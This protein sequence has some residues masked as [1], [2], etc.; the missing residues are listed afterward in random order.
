VEII[1]FKKQKIFMEII[2]VLKFCWTLSFFIW[3]I[4]ELYPKFYDSIFFTQILQFYY[5]IYL[6]TCSWI[7]DFYSYKKNKSDFTIFVKIEKYPILL[8]IH[9]Y[10]NEYDYNTIFLVK[11]CNK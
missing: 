9:E 5:D 3:H 10:I 1:P 4:V 6:L 2:I 11:E 7:S 8:Y